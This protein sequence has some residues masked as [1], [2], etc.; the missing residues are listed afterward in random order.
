MKRLLL[1]VFLVPLLGI[2]VIKKSPTG[3]TYERTVPGFTG[4]NGE[5]QVFLKFYDTAFSIITY[6]Y[7]DGRYTKDSTFGHWRQVK[8]TIYLASNGKVDSAQV[9]IEEIDG[10]KY[11]LLIFRQDLQYSMIR[12]QGQ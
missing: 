3:K 11:N 4:T 2:G 7:N 9:L 6:L 5:T 12:T 1:L 8:D 10:L